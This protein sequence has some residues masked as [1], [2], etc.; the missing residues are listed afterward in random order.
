MYKEL[1]R[2]NKYQETRSRVGRAPEQR[3]MENGN[4]SERHIK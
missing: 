4:I 1:I 2:N 3:Y